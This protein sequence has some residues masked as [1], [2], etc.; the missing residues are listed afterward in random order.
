MYKIFLMAILLLLIIALTMPAG[1]AESDDRARME[2]SSKAI[3]IVNG[4]NGSYSDVL[5]VLSPAVFPDEV[6]YIFNKPL[7]VDVS[8]PMDSFKSGY[9]SSVPST[10]KIVPL[11]DEPVFIELWKKTFRKDGVKIADRTLVDSVKNSV[12][13]F[14]SDNSKN[15]YS[16][17]IKTER[18]ATVVVAAKVLPVENNVNYG[19]C[20]KTLI[21][22]EFIENNGKW[23]LYSLKRR[24]RDECMAV[25]ENKRPVY[26]VMTPFF[27]ECTKK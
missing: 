15:K 12:N 5:K 27:D 22:M 6:D 17:V 9:C 24:D 3:S 10:G 21:T 7:D 16:Y 14:H 2:I 13:D 25:P 11:Y 1:A 18:K 26:K 8:F 4:L 20:E 23:W 19:P